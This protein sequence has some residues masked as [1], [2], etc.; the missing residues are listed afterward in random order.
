MTE[1]YLKLSIGGLPPFSSREC[2]QELSPIKSAEVHR[3]VNGELVSTIS[4][5][6]QKYQTTI[7]GNDKLP[8]A[9]DCLWKGQDVDVSCIQMLW[10][11]AEEREVELNR[12]PVPSSLR[13]INDERRAVDVVSVEGK[14]VVLEAPGYVGYRPVLKMKLIDFGYETEE[15]GDG[16]I[17]WYLKLEEI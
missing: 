3:T 2:R 6:H 7:K 16:A 8:A 12:T 1:T 17:S 5:H 10:Q 9:I 14:H 11:K 4:K 13:A 15:W